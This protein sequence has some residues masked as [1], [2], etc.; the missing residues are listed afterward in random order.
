[1]SKSLET[2]NEDD[3]LALPL[4]E[5]DTFERKGSK[6][7][8][9]TLSGVKESE[10]LNELAKQLSAFSNT[11]GGRVV[12]GVANNGTVDNGGVA[13]SIKGSTKEW[14][15][16][17]VPTL[18][19]F[20]IVGF[21]VYEIPP[22]PTNSKIAP[23]KALYVVDVPDSDRAPH[24]S[25]RDLKYYVR[26]G[27]KSRP[28]RHRMIED[29]RNRQKHPT[30]ELKEIRLEIIDPSLF[31]LT[32]DPPKF[33]GNFRIRFYIHLKNSGRVMAKNTCLQLQSSTPFRWENY[34]N[35]AVRRRGTVPGPVFW[36]LCD[37]VYPGMDIGFWV[38]AVVS[39][40]FGSV[41][42][43]WPGGGPWCV[44]GK[45]ISDIRL[46]WSLFADNAPSNEGNDTVE[47]LGFERAAW[48]A[49]DKLGNA[50]QIR[51]VFPGI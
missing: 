37:P 33:A 5:N 6:S 29:I 25:A 7:L 4:G 8:D 28:A 9:L 43:D 11:G 51:R 45:E 36:E 15:E 39:G 3:V 30:V 32:E 13:V 18:T 22:N 24:Q 10:V 31:T 19:E 38:D 41:R 49:I 44:E 14:I 23:G 16:D 17:V 50:R 26:L 46:S 1:M 21:N 34:D 20:E 27:G 12:Y 35:Q 48:Q 40:G 47:G 42:P 2:W